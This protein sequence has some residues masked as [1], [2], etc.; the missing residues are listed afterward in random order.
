[1]V[2]EMGFLGLSW[3]DKVVSKAKSYLTIAQKNNLSNSIVQLIHNK[4]LSMLSSGFKKVDFVD[5]LT[6]LALRKWDQ[7]SY[8]IINTIK[9]E[10]DLNIILVDA[11]FRSIW[12]LSVNGKISYSKLDP[13]GVQTDKTNADPLQD[14]TILDVLK[15]GF[16]KTKLTIAIG[17]GIGVL[18]LLGRLKK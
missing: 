14:K 2:E 15:L 11:V 1:M 18:Y 4:Y 10:L 8:T 5:T 16:N 17:A 9:N 6:N 13:I 12:E 3:L 7:Q